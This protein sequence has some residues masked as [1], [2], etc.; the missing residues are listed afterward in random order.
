MKYK[1]DIKEAERVYEQLKECADVI[2]STD[3]KMQQIN[4]S[5][6]RLEE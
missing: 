4:E 3:Y 6:R 2:A 1:K 5:I